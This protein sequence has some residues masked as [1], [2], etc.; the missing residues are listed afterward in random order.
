MSARLLTIE[1]HTD[2][3]LKTV[4][5]KIRLKGR[6]LQRLG[7]Q[8]GQRVAVFAAPGDDSTLILRLWAAPEPSQPSA[9]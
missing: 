3:K 9:T 6:W 2:A 7:F 1:P 5:S 4:G 8:P